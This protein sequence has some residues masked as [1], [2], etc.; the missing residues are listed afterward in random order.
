MSDVVSDV[1]HL[2]SILAVTGNLLYWIVYP[3]G[4]TL[5]YI[6]QVLI[7]LLQFLV[8]PIA[9]L[10]QPVFYLGAFLLNCLLLPFRAIAKF[11]TLY[12]YLSIAAL[13]GLLIGL[14]VRTTYARLYKLLNL[15]SK[16][17]PTLRSAKQYREEKHQQKIKSDPVLAARHMGGGSV[18]SDYLSVS[19]SSRKG[20]RPRSLLAQTILE[21][22]DSDL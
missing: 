2:R 12:I 16:P 21:E 10:L 7:Q 22:G 11:E 1:S 20:K 8:R 13:V 9:F 19:D 6:A 5:W 14:L 18:S 15:D 4:L 17:P 3:I